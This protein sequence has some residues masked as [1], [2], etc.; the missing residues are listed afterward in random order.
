MH[1]L[2][3]TASLGLLLASVAVAAGQ[4]AEDPGRKVRVAY[5]GA[6]TGLLLEAT[7]ADL[8]NSVILRGEELVITKEEFDTFVAQL[9]AH[10]T[11]QQSPDPLLLLEYFAASRLLP[12]LAGRAAATAEKAANDDEDALV[13]AFLEERIADI[14]VSEEEISAFYAANAAAFA[15][16]PLDSVKS[17]VRQYVMQEKRRAAID[18]VI[19]NLGTEVPLELSATWLESAAALSLDN[20]IDRARGMKKPLLVVFSSASCCGTDT[21]QTVSDAV[22]RL[23]AGRVEVLHLDARRQV[24]LGMR[25][26]V[27]AS[28]TIIGYAPSG[29]ELFRQTGA[30][31]AEELLAQLDSAEP[32]VP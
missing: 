23:G 19:R 9:P 31:N 32:A 6:A 8:D 11:V 16:A 21:M 30:A 12:I 22:R 13:Q 7:V 15:G 25:F 24:L 28:P 14:E 29:D 20:P 27:R 2:R 1:G 10:L 5:P 18:A 17:Y 26:G 4:P 3:L